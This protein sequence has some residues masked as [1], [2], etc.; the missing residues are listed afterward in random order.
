MGNFID[1]TGEINYNNQGEKVTIIR[2][3]G[4]DDIDVQFEDG[5]IVYNRRYGNFI[6]GRIKHPIKYEESFAY[7]IEVELGIDLDDIW[8][9]EKNNELGIN[10]YEIYK[11]SRKKV[12]LYCQEKDYHNYD[13]ESNKVGY[14]ITCASFYNGS[15]CGYC[16]NHKIHWKDS[17]AYVLPKVA[18]MIAI[19]ENNLT[20]EDCYDIAPFSSKKFYFKCD[21]CGNISNKKYILYQITNY[22]YSCKFCSDGISIP[23]KFMANILKQLNENFIC[24]LSKVDFE[25]CE[26][27][28]YDFY[29]PKYNMIIE[30]NGEQHYKKATGSWKENRNEQWND[31][32]KYKCAKSYVDNYIV[33]DCRY[34]ELEWIKENIM[35]ELNN[36]FDLNRVDWKLAWEE[37]QNSLCIKALELWENGFSQKEI[38]EKINVH[39]DTVR[40]WL[41][42][43]GVENQYKRKEKNKLK[44][45]EFKEQGFTNF[46]IS[47]KI[48]VTERTIYKWLE[49]LNK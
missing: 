1:R 31:L 11:C 8:N 47:K 25:W 14:K 2:Y 36:Y 24:E 18:K 48:G 13:K 7:H 40:N 5:T 19:K 44:L 12:W 9:W 43:M 27:F 37:S 3:G 29:L 39:K 16:G 32:F 17:L 33:I 6:R 20:F 10:P 41:R 26:D 21:E 42:K 35:K 22:K 30:V 4:H 38:S 23:N 45:L 15:R 46:E 28:K 34:S 49:E